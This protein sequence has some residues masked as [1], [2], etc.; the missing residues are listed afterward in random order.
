MSLSRI[1]SEINGDFSRK[2]QNCPTPTP[3]YY[4]PL[5]KG[6]PLKLGIGARGQ[7]TRMMMG[8]LGRERSLLISSAVWIGLQCINMTDGRTDR[9]TPGDSKD[10]TYA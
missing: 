8:L 6:F 7:K 9:R 10:R 4:A 1:V 2:A 5:L 3:V